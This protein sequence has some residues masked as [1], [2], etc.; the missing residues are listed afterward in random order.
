MVYRLTDLGLRKLKAKLREQ[1]PNL[2]GDALHKAMCEKCELSIHPVENIML[3]KKG[4]NHSSL[5]KLFLAYNIFLGDD[6]CEEWGTISMP[7][8]TASQTPKPLQGVSRLPYDKNPYF[9]GRDADLEALHNALNKQGT[10]A[11]TGPG[12]IGKSTLVAEYAH[13]YSEEYRAVL[14]F[15][16]ENRE[17]LYREIA[18]LSY[19]L[20]PN[21]PT[22]APQE[23]R[24]RKVVGWLH[25]AESQK[26]LILLDNADTPKI[27]RDFL[28]TY[29]LLKHKG[30]LLITSRNEHIRKTFHIAPLQLDALPPDKATEF[31]WARTKK[32]R[33]K[34]PATEREAAEK[35]A[36]TLYGYPL[37][38]E[39][40]G[41]YIDHVAG[42][43]TFT[44]Y[45]AEY[46]DREKRLS[47]MGYG[48]DLTHYEK[49]VLNTWSPNFEALQ[50]DYPFAADMLGFCAYLAPD[51]IPYELLEAYVELYGEGADC[52][53]AIGEITAYSLLMTNTVDAEEEALP[54][55]RM[56]GMVR[57]ILKQ[58]DNDE[59]EE[60]RKTQ[61]VKALVKA[62]PNGD[63]ENYFAWGRGCLRLQWQWGACLDWIGS[64]S[65]IPEGDVLL[66]NIGYF[67]QLQGRYGEAEP[68]HLQALEISRKPLPEGHHD[69]AQVLNNLAM[70]YESQGRY[71]EAEALH[72]QALEMRK[73]IFP[74]GHPELGNSLSNLAGLY[75]SQ[76]RYEEA[77]AL[78]LQALE[79]LL[80][81]F[82]EGHPQ[83]T[84]TV[85][86]LEALQQDR[87]NRTKQK[88]RGK[89]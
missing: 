58:R 25:G 7:T 26:W 36:T 5:D 83:I 1:H 49:T 23:E 85:N 38:L 40:A 75:K 41:A 50:E 43:R 57:D 30:H 71:G 42:A 22:D 61:V 60:R 77:E 66:N 33:V 6:C 14:W 32:D 16:A 9:T 74:E 48:D 82:P 10:A 69:I 80:K 52:A 15:G 62:Y 34:A 17:T 67:Y 24:V 64:L 8:P 65:A 12:G 84:L 39:Q 88:P 44:K 68:L 27:A 46:Q 86:N 28:R 45:L 11:I 59:E 87:R 54:T 21:L 79:M 20:F 4:A 72:L 53:T 2:T 29:H 76:G 55:Y 89:R 51:S 31:L 56:H 13:R 63:A 35:L 47:L 70:V 18:D 81:F 3:R 19:N 78:H 37:A 73:K